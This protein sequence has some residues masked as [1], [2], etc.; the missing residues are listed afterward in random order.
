MKK[1][2]DWSVEIQYQY[3]QAQAI[4]EGDVSGIGRGN[5]LDESFTTCSRRGEGNYK[6]WRFESLYAITDNLIIDTIYEFSN[7]ANKQIGGPHEYE[8][9]EVETIYAL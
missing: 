5:V 4:P 6:G 9:F 3:V 8:K 7:A 2:G 1:E